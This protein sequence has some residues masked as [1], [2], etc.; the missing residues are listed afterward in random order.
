MDPMSLLM[1]HF[2]NCDRLPDE[3][4]D[5]RIGVNPSLKRPAEELCFELKYDIHDCD[6][7]TMNSTTDNVTEDSKLLS[8]DLVQESTSV[9]S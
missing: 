4:H 5:D 1:L 3:L 6:F 2:I 8:A 7:K 9:D